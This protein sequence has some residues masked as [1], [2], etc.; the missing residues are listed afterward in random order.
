MLGVWSEFG[1][2]IILVNFVFLGFWLMLYVY[3][4]GSKM[5][6]IVKFYLGFIGNGWIRKYSGFLIFFMFIRFIRIS[7][8]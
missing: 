1:D 6:I 2:L 4:V 3:R 8:I 7:L 5:E